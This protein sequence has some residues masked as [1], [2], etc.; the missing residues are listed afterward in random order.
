MNTAENTRHP[1]E[2]PLPRMEALARLPVFFALDGKR[3]IVAGSGPGAAWKVE[4]LSAAGARVDVYAGDATEEF[5]DLAA[6]PPRGPVQVHDRA[7]A[8]AD[9]AG[10]AI[11]IGG[12]ADDADAAR[13]AQAA[14][15]AGV[16]VNVIDK[17]QFCDFAFGAIVNRS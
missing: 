5:A 8:Q 13:F 14:R 9:L 15:A 16:P 7:W 2:A 17:P 11:A 3:A 1:T 6:Q 4:L 12:F 10:A